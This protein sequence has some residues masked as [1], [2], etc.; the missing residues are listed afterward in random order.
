MIA[1]RGHLGLGWP[2]FQF[3]GT[4]S[5]AATTSLAG[6]TGISAGTLSSG[7]WTPERPVW[8][9]SWYESAQ[10]RQDDRKWPFWLHKK[11]C[12]WHWVALILGR[13]AKYWFSTAATAGGT[14]E[15]WAMQTT[16]SATV[17]ADYLALCELLSF[18]LKDGHQTVHVRR[19]V[20][21]FADARPY[22][23]LQ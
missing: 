18:I 5:P 16:F 13:G 20:F 12:R 17:A 3:K 9:I 2:L 23:L 4:S 21:F 14:A 7:G 19:R 11:H 15:G 10:I 6:G 8:C 1:S 22:E